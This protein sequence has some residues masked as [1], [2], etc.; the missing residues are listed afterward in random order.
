MTTSLNQLGMAKS[1]QMHSNLGKVHSDPKRGGSST[2]YFSALAPLK[3]SL[4]CGW[5]ESV[6]LSA[7]T[8]AGQWSHEVDNLTPI[9][10]REVLL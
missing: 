3:L 1:K 6:H 8:P 5:L 7:E 2:T 9:P 4:G 10:R